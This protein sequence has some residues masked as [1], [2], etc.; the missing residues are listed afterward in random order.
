MSE[1][2]QKISLKLKKQNQITTGTAVE[3][4]LKMLRHK[5]I[6]FIKTTNLFNLF[7]QFV[8]APLTDTFPPFSLI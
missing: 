2:S 5:T 8:K 7:V 6:E 4:I 3:G 1:L